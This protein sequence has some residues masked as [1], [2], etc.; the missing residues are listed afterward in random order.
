MPQ[1]ATMIRLG[2]LLPKGQDS[3]TA[4]FRSALRLEWPVLAQPGLVALVTVLAV[5]SSFPCLIKALLGSAM[6]DTTPILVALPKIPKALLDSTL[7]CRATLDRTI[8]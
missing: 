5:T 2:P 3:M 4:A 6:H 1:Q 8:I 7:Q